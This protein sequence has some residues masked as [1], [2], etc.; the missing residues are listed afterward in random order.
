MASQWA[1]HALCR[2]VGS[3]L[4]IASGKRNGTHLCSSIKEFSNFIVLK[5]SQR[6]C[7]YVKASLPSNTMHLPFLDLAAS[8]MF[9]FFKNMAQVT[10]SFGVQEMEIHLCYFKIVKQ[11]YFK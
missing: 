3:W 6:T 4:F 10:I 8:H 5:E 2:F 7:V 9:A 1:N 11:I